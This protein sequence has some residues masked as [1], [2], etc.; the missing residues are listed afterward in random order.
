MVV[1]AEG[2]EVAKASVVPN[3]DV[4]LV[5]PLV[6]SAPPPP[7]PPSAEPADPRGKI[8]RGS[9]QRVPTPGK[10]KGDPLVTKYPF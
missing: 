2:Y 5:V 6:K 9:G 10:G 7:P 1:A 3:R 4:S 8:P